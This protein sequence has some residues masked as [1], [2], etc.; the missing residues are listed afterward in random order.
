MG[1]GTR[2]RGSNRDASP[3]HTHQTALATRR[4]KHK[5]LAA[6]GL[7]V[8]AGILGCGSVILGSAENGNGIFRLLK[9]LRHEV[10]FVSE[11]AKRL[12][13]ENAKSAAYVV[14][15]L[16]TGHGGKLCDVSLRYSSTAGRKF[17]IEAA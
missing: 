14:K 6:V 13:V 15:T 11:T 1:G 2:S 8:A 5:I 17:G 10:P 12:K 3:E 7:S 16:Y 4:L 9:A